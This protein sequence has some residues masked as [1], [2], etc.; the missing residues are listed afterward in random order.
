MPRSSADQTFCLNMIVKNEAAVI[1]RCLESVK[2]ILDSW[3]I[4]DTGSTDGTQNIIRSIL[5]DIPGELHERPWRNFGHNRSEAIELASPRADYLFFIDADE[6][7]ETAEGFRLPEL[8]R[9]AYQLAMRS[10]ANEYFR[11]GLVATRLKW[12]SVGVL[13][14][15]LEADRPY[16]PATL[17]GITVVAVGDGGRSQGISVIE[18]Y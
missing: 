6:V 10:G 13:H 17:D 4:V 11:L 18:K 12:R 8:D 1:A 16:A 5:K 7:L 15:Y 14:E 2:P 3:C 9:D